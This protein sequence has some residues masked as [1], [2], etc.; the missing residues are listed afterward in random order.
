[1]PL[2]VPAEGHLGGVRGENN[3]IVVDEGEAGEMVHLGLG[4]GSLPVATA[5]LNDLIG[6]FNPARSW[7]GRY[8]RAEHLPHAPRFVHYL[9]RELG[10]TVITDTP[11]RGAVPLLDSLIGARRDL[12]TG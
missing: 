10:A 11:G 2:A 7:T 12:K 4:A 3:V 6:L 5:A 9:A 1:M 8:P